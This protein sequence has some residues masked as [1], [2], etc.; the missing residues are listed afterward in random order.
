MYTKIL[1]YTHFLQK[2]EGKLIENI[3]YSENICKYNV[4]SKCK[5]QPF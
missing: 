2:G 3:K 1:T 4:I 5:I